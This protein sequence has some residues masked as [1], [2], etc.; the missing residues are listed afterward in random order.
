MLQAK[1]HS[2]FAPEDI[3]IVNDSAICGSHLNDVTVIMPIFVDGKVARVQ[4][5]QGPLE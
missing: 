4:R 5:R 2:A 3:W 1:G